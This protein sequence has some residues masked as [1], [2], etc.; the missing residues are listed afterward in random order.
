MQIYL[1]IVYYISKVEYIS[2]LHSSGLRGLSGGV[3]Y[4]L[5]D[6]EKKKHSGADL[7]GKNVHLL[8]NF[9]GSQGFE[10]AG[11]TTSAY[12]ELTFTRMWV[13]KRPKPG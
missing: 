11:A 6:G 1:D 13:L 8:L 10:F 7:E 3:Y 4:F 12:N 2:I 9:F 5:P